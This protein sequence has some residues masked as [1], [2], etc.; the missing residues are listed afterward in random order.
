[1]IVNQEFPLASSFIRRLFWYILIG[2]TLY[3]VSNVLVVFPWI[4]SKTSGII[5]MFLS[6]FLW[7]YITCYCFRHVPVKERNRDTIFMGISFLF[8][9]VVQDYLLYAVYREVPDELY[10]PTTF[11]A[12]GLIF[13]LPFLVRYVIMRKD[14]SIT[15]RMVTG[16]KLM[17]T[18][19][20]GIAA[21]L[22]TF[23]T[24]RYW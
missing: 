24:M 6:T 11:L 1:M 15:V 10:E 16:T 23:W 2:I 17:T 18:A 13:I 8:T 5:A 20:I 21:F 7:G 3:W 4:I 22:F 9:G 12:Y 14:G 19:I